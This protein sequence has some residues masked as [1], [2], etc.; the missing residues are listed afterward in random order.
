M[1][2][3]CSGR[4]ALYEAVGY[5]QTPRDRALGEPYL[6]A[7]RSRLSEAEWEMAFAEGQAMSFEEAVEYALSAEEAQLTGAPAPEQPSTGARQL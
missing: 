3:G 1:R 7:A 5:H 6:A 2:L 4:R